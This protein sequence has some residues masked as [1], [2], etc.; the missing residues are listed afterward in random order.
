MRDINKINTMILNDL[1]DVPASYY[2]TEIKDVSIQL[3]ELEE[4]RQDDEF[5][6]YYSYKLIPL[7]LIKN[8]Q[9]IGETIFIDFDVE[10]L[11]S[12][13]SD[14]GSN[15]IFQEEVIRS[16]QKHFSLFDSDGNILNVD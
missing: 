8:D 13:F 1:I 3:L 16:I 6:Y 9:N 5:E 4:G 10:R 14:D 7:Q 11:N 12:G 15:W 2:G